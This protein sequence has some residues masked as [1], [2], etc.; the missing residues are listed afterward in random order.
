M[1]LQ[2]YEAAMREPKMVGGAQQ[3]AGASFFALMLLTFAATPWL[4][5]AG[6]GRA[7][8]LLLVLYA[9]VAGNVLSVAAIHSMEVSRY[10]QVLFLVALLAHLWALRCCL[11]GVMAASAFVRRESRILPRG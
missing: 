8:G 3:R 4:V 1:R 5:R 11:A 6:F 10:S 7:V 2:G 9:L